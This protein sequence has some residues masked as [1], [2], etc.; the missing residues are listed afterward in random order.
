M[1]RTSAAIVLLLP[2]LA[3]GFL[4]PAGVRRTGRLAVTAPEPWEVELTGAPS[5][6]KPTTESPAGAPE[7]RD[8]CQVVERAVIR[9]LLVEPAMKRSSAEWMGD[10]LWAKA[11]TML[12][13]EGADADAVRVGDRGINANKLLD[14]FSSTYP[15][16]ASWEREDAEIFLSCLLHVVDNGGE[17]EE[18]AAALQ[19]RIQPYSPLYMRFTNALRVAGCSLDRSAEALDPKDYNIC[20]SMGDAFTPPGEKAITLT[21]SRRPSLRLRRRLGGGRSLILT[22]ILTLTLDPSR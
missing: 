2:S 6:P 11:L 16:A 4:A 19:R 21:L 7:I 5:L 14:A 15:D 1:P 9:E 18:K 3:L 13:L 10:A 12:G 20:F 17:D 8:F 22:P